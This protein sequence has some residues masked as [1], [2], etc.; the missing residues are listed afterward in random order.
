MD[1]T[2]S[3]DTST[4]VLDY[5]QQFY[6]WKFTPEAY[7]EARGRA[8]EMSGVRYAERFNVRA[9]HGQAVAYLE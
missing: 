5:Y 7:R 3:I 1:I 2:E 9:A 4:S 6:G 8:G